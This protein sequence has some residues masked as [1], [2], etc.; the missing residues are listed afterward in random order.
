MPAADAIKDSLPQLI[1]GLTTVATRK[2]DVI[3]SSPRTTEPDGTVVIRIS[4][5]NWES[6]RSWGSA[7][8]VDA[9][10]DCESYDPSQDS[11]CTL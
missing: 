6:I 10:E 7:D 5:G 3:F 8:F 9:D 2:C 4:P 1:A 11:A